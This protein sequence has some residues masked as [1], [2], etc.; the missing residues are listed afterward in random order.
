MKLSLSG[1]PGGLFSCF[2]GLAQL[3]GEIKAPSAKADLDLPLAKL[4]L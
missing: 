1:S 4:R 2:A 3:G